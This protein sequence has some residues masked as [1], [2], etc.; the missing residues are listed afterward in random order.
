[1]RIAKKLPKFMT[2]CRISLQT[3]K[4]LRHHVT[5]FQVLLKETLSK[6]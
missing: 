3:Q 5:A 4:K 1:M 2:K 6:T